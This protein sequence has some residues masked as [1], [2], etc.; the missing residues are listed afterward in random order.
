[1]FTTARV[2]ALVGV[3]VATFTGLANDRLPWW[4]IALGATVLAVTQTIA[5][6]NGD[7]RNGPKA[8]E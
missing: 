7:V 2:V 4:G 5:A 1:M 8:K 6:F 3:A